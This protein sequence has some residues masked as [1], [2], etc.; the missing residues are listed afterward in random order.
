MTRV[1]IAD[2]QAPTR[3]G[4]RMLLTGEPGIEV[5]GAAVD[6]ADLVALAERRDPDVVLTDIRMPRMDGLAAIRHLMSLAPPPAVIALT[7]FDLDEYL[8]G[9]L[10]AGAVGFLLKDSDP[11]LFVEAIRAAE[12]GQGLIDPQVTRRLVHRFAATSPRPATAELDELTAR[13][14]EVLVELARGL[15]NAEI[16]AVLHIAPGTVK[17]HVARILAKLG[18]ATRVQAVIYAHRHGVVTWDDA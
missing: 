15:S 5:I 6:G 2:D 1:L 13:E 3:D 11:A 8:F 9:A 12:R 14:R 18:L 4:L 17:I 10:Q 7:T 16:A